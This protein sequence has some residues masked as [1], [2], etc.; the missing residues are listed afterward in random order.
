MRYTS[1]Q[2]A[3]TIASA[4]L[5]WNTVLG[6]VLHWSLKFTI[7]RS[8]YEQATTNTMKQEPFKLIEKLPAFYG[9][10]RIIIVLTSVRHRTPQ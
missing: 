3:A 1:W 7:N 4:V 2:A 5:Y 8:R 10:R 6:F 9:I